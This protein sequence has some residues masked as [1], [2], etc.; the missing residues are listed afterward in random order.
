MVI[1]NALVMQEFLANKFV[2]TLFSSVLIFVIIIVTVLIMSPRET[3]FYFTI[4]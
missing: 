4:N 1:P 3:L 2:Y